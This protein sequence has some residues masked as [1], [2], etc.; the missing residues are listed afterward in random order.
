[1]DPVGPP[2][3]SLPVLYSFS[4]NFSM[5]LAVLHGEVINVILGLYLYYK[6]LPPCKIISYWICR[7]TKKET[8]RTQW[9]FKL[10][11]LKDL[12]ANFLWCILNYKY[13][14][15]FLFVLLLHHIF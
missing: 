4:K 15:S 10:K 11:K 12:V 8:D 2:R 13:R 14:N 6:I 3:S 1:M 9:V 5:S 7:K